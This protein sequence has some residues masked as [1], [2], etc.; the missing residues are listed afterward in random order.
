MTQSPPSSDDEGALLFREAQTAVRQWRAAHPRATFSEIEEAVDAEMQRVR[1]RVVAETA[2][3]GAAWEE[4]P[5]PPVCPQ[6]GQRMQARGIRER[7][8]TVAGD[9]PITLTRTYTVCPTCGTGLFP[10]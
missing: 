6:C 1:A 4:T 3:D 10:P 9:Q 7:T 5:M 2:G 8:I